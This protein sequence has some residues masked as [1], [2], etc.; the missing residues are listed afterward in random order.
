[1][2]EEIKIIYRDDNLLVVDKPA[3]LVVASKQKQGRQSVMGVLTDRFPDLKNVG[4]GPRYGLVHRLDKETSGVLLVARNEKSLKFFQEQFKKRRV[5]KKYLALV[6]GRLK[7]ESGRIESLIGRSPQN[8]IKQK[9]YFSFGPDAGGKRKAITVYQKK[10]VFCIQKRNQKYFYTL[11]EAC[12]KTGRK[13]QIRVH[14]HYLH[15][16]IAGDKMY[17]FKNQKPPPGLKRQF[18]HASFL[19][20]KNLDGRERE[21]SSPLPPDLKK[22]LDKLDEH[23]G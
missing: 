10:K 11:L 13:H 19:R 9:V 7:K 4:P 12:P 14:L 21:F 23:I 1:M 8:R 17:S 6:Y 5:F 20:I 3:P 16:P 15:H 2:R 18:L 22:I